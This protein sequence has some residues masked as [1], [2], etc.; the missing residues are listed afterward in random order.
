MSQKR[1]QVQLDPLKLMYKV[2]LLVS[3]MPAKYQI[4]KILWLA[5]RWNKQVAEMHYYTAELSGYEV[6]C[7]CSGH[8]LINMGG[9]VL[10][11]FLNVLNLYKAPYFFYGDFLLTIFLILKI[12]YTHN[13]LILGLSTSIV[14]YIICYFLCQL[15]FLSKSSIRNPSLWSFGIWMSIKWSWIIMCCHHV[16]ITLF[17]RLPGFISC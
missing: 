1:K 3:R 6:S 11:N 15:S 16:E 7:F 4:F 12:I 13:F 14:H 17:K 10:V 5:V 8:H 9:C 2:L